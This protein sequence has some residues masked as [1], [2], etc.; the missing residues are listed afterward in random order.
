[1]IL[2]RICAEGVNY[3]VGHGF[4]CIDLLSSTSTTATTT[5]QQP[6]TEWEGLRPVPNKLAIDD[7]EEVA[8]HILVLSDKVYY[9]LGGSTKKR[10]RKGEKLRSPWA[11]A[12]GL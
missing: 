10:R 12:H 1:M 8:A 2:Y 6:M 7:V 11:M 5:M 9:C 4:C 3:F